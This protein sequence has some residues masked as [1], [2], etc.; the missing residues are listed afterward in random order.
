MVFGR[1]ERVELAV[2]YILARP[3]IP[4]DPIKANSPLPGFLLVV[5]WLE[6]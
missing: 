6:S 4:R 5:M 2:A 1:E 3:E